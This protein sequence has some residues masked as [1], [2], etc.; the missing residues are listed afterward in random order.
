MT[1]FKFFDQRQP[2]RRRKNAAEMV[3]LFNATHPVGTRIRVW[4]GVRGDNQHS[5][6]TV[7]AAPGAFVTASNH[8]VVKIPGDSIALT[9][10]EVITD[11]PSTTAAREAA[12]E[13]LAQRG[14]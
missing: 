14:G 12:A 13:M 11:V 4:R 3:A 5:I 6:D 2:R 7:V 1:M 10:V 9:H 8:A